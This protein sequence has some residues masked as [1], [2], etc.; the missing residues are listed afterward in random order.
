MELLA[1]IN[2]LATV[3]VAKLTVKMKGVFLPLQTLKIEVAQNT[4][5]VDLILKTAIL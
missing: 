1:E 4:I 3:N 2:R 5:A